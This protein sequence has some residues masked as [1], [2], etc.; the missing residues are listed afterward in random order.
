MELDTHASWTAVSPPGRSTSIGE[1]LLARSSTCTT[2]NRLIFFS[3]SFKHNK[4]Q[5]ETETRV[6]A[7]SD[8]YN[9]FY[10]GQSQQKNTKTSGE[11]GADFFLLFA[12]CVFCWTIFFWRPTNTI[13]FAFSKNSACK[14]LFSFVN[15]PTVNKIGNVGAAAETEAFF[16]NRPGK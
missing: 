5:L 16:F 13:K 9:S 15:R 3:L 10:V 8:G 2:T 14:K 4:N 12:V 6:G 7:H 1:G 11:I